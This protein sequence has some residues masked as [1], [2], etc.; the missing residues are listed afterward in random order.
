M[1]AEKVVDYAKS[2]LKK[3]EYIFNQK[4]CVGQ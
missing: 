4:I 3:V 2:N 1:S